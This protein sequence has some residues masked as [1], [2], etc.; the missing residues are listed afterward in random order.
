MGVLKK[1]WEEE[2]EESLKSLEEA[3]RRSWMIWTVRVHGGV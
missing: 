3:E 2:A 1:V